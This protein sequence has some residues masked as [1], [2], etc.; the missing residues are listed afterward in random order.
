[1]PLLITPVEAVSRLTPGVFP[2]AV[3][4]ALTPIVMLPQ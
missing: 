1:M 2:A 3:T 4:S